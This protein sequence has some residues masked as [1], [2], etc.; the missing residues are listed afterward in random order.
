[1]KGVTAGAGSM[2]FSPVLQSMA[3]KID[4]DYVL[5][6]RVVFVLFDNGFHET[7]SLPV[8]MDV[9]ADVIR[10]RALSELTLPADIAPFDRLK[11]RLTIV[12]GLRGEHVYPDHG[13]GF[14]ALSGVAGGVGRE[15]H[16]RAVAESIDAAIARQ[17]P[18]VFP[19]LVLGIDPGNASTSTAVVSSAWGPGRGIAAQC[20]P[21]LAFESLFGTIGARRND[22][23][24]RK[25]L[26][27]FVTGDVKRLRTELAGPEREQL[28]YH[29]GA[30][31]SLSKR[32]GEL[33]EMY[34]R[35][36]LETNI[37]KLPVKSDLMRETV[38]AQFEIAAS[39]LVTGLTSVV[40]ITSGLCSIGK[41]YSGFS[42]MSVHALGHNNKDTDLNLMGFEILGRVRRHIAEQA[43]QLLE[44][45]RSIPEDGGTMLDNTLLVFT[46][47]S[48]NRQHTQG[49]NWPFVIV[50]NLGGRLRAGDLVMYPTQPAAQPRGDW[51]FHI[52]GAKTNPKI[53][54]LYCTLLHAIGAPREHFNMPSANKMSV[55]QYGVLPELLT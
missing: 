50:G 48:A 34:D 17:L 35:G 40:T 7:A 12:H 28:D 37:P 52:A 49:E 45:L 22:F 2:L 42:N 9:G 13:A 47:D 5:P 25:S 4:G 1:L 44:K 46:S 15:K 38:T 20:R 29:L 3:G 24:T 6:K 54:A 39:A 18:G 43:V 41:S 36:Q 14:G 19:L 53:N 51:A 8:E 21:E 33:A 23:R 55:S 26:L 27:D 30:L 11:E 31:E 16:R 10:R 32:D